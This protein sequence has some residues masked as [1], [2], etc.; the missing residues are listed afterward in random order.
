MDND[1]KI[2]ST[3]NKMSNK[4]NQTTQG[5]TSQNVNNEPGTSG[6]SSYSS[7]AKQPPKPKQKS[8]RGAADVHSD[9]DDDSWTKFTR[10]RRPK[11]RSRT[12]NVVYGTR[13]APAADDAAAG[14]PGLASTPLTI[15][16]VP[17]FAHVYI[18]QL[19]KGTTPEAL[20]NYVEA[21][22]GFTPPTVEKIVGRSTH[23]ASF[24]IAVPFQRQKDIMDPDLWPED[25]VINRYYFPRSAPALRG[26]GNPQQGPAA[27]QRT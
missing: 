3:L 13:R 17:R 19:E 10:R 23:A 15:Q 11:G 4:H 20:T 5:R 24:H 26:E 21:N 27:R 2:D 18:G 16:A 9:N 7:A 8:D 6:S 14:Q 1:S 22:C 25:T 12:A